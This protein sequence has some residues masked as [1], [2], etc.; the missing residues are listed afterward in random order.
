MYSKYWVN[1]KQFIPRVQIEGKARW[2]KF[3]AF[4][5][6]R[7]KCSRNKMSRNFFI[8]IMNIC[9]D[10]HKI[11]SSITSSTEDEDVHFMSWY[12]YIYVLR[13]CNN[14]Q[15]MLKGCFSFK[16]T[17]VQTKT[18][19]ILLTMDLFCEILLGAKEASYFSKR[20]S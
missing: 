3:A 4:F 16:C 11:T 9:T 2:C 8:K 1:K 13:T 12:I 10:A 7:A 14:I 20:L 5:L 15:V 17:S 6:G 19:G 18:C